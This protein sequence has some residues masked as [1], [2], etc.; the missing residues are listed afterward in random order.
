LNAK[1]FDIAK[2]Y[3]EIKLFREMATSA[4]KV[5]GIVGLDYQLTGRLNDEMFPILPSVKGGGTLTLKDVKLAGFKMMNAVSKE[6]KRDSLTN[7][8]LKDVV[9][10]TSIKNNIM[11]IERTKMKIAGFRPRFE[12]EVSL[13]GRL[14]LKGRLGLPPF[15]L[16]GIPL[17]VTGTQEKPIIKLK[18]NKDGKLEETEDADSK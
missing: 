6:T 17:S 13:D 2:A 9:V 11:T 14:N 4:S 3:K 15:G 12:G 7:P 8:N 16:I 10:K 5:K 18:R 1:E